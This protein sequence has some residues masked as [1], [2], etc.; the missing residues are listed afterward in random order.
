MAFRDLWRLDGTASRKT[1]AL[2]GLIGFAIKHNLDRVIA[3][4]FFPGFP[5]QGFVGHFFNYWAPLGKAASIDHLSD[6]ELQFL[7]IILL[8]AMPFIWVGVAITVR[9]LR[10][11]GLPVWLVVFF[12]A[13]FLNLAF[14]AALCL[15]PPGERP[16]SQEAAPW[17]GSDYIIHRIHLRVLNHIRRDS[18]DGAKLESDVRGD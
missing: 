12:F 15:L 13:P 8:T 7:A 2:V 6:P 11:A 17:P 3:M 16:V 18:G 4:R 10:D 5:G 9:R 1:Y 14:F